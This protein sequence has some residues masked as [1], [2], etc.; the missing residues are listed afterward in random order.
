[1]RYLTVREAKQIAPIS[2]ATLYRLIA[3]GEIGFIK[4]GRRTAIPEWELRRYLESL[5]LTQRAKSR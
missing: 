5:P 4:I 3:A 2:R 1:M